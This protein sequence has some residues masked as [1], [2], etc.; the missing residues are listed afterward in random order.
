MLGA[1]VPGARE[2]QRIDHAA[3]W[4]AWSAAAFEL[5]IEEAKVEAGVMRHEWR[6]LDEIEQLS[7]LVGEQRLV[8]H[9][10]VGPVLHHLCPERQ[11]P[12]GEGIS[13]TGTAR[14]EP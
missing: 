9:A 6:V 10:G 1:W 7:G 4:H 14:L 5:G 12:L 3:H 13:V 11:L 2:S 8:R